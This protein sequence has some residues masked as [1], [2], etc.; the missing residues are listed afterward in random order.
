MN[1]ARPEEQSLAKAWSQRSTL[2]R[3]AVLAAIAFAYFLA[4]RAGLTLSFKGT[5]A[6][7]VWPAS[8]IAMAAVLA[9]GW[10]A[11]P[12]VLVGAWIAN[13]FQ[14]WGQSSLGGVGCV[15]G[16]AIVAGGNTL[17]ALAGRFALR[18]LGVGDRP[19]DRVQDAFK[20]AFM[21]MAAPVV[22][23][24]V[25]WVSI[26]AFGAEPHA[27]TL[28]FWLTWWLG[29]T[30]GIL[31]YTPALL[32]WTWRW[33][34][35]WTK[36][37]IAE[38]LL[39]GLSLVPL[40]F[41]LFGWL[42]EPMVRSL[43]Y[44]VMPLLLWVVLR[45]S[46]REAA[47]AVIIVAAIATWGTVQGRGPFAASTLNESLLLLQSFVG[48][49]AVTVL[50]LSA[51]VIERQHFNDALRRMNRS[52]EE[53][54]TKRTSELS[55]A[56]D[57]LSEEVRERQHAEQVVRHLAQHDSL[58]GLANRRLLV[59]LYETMEALARRRDGKMALLFIDLDDFKPINDT[60]GHSAG[61]E[62]LATVASRLEGAV[63]ESDLVA[64]FGGDEFVVVL[65]EV[66]ESEDAL[67]VA[68]KI[69]TVL[70]DPVDIRGESRRL[71]VS[72]GIATY[73]RNARDLEGLLRCADRAMY[74]VKQSGKNGFA[75]FED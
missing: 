1:E 18:K 6:T 5:N 54:V 75:A 48:T 30:A 16:A 3:A 68:A 69:F 65:P 41:V 58:T 7:P 51:A 38:A 70:T 10:R 44:L 22:A 52:L 21:G 50:A 13:I 20:F 24:S 71:G 29:D 9:F 17:E 31:V 53:R 36:A 45:F 15:L 46:L 73:P 12:G 35:R 72:I 4:A 74:G 39:L 8:G 25:G 60:F 47:T 64:R 37:R 43:P 19:F 66:T 40:G 42:P 27:R 2:E 14:F 55:E 33:P 56:N 11:W 49:V 23:A 63:R 32:A 34:T 28:E 61:D 59:A 26:F 67:Q 57:K 62:V